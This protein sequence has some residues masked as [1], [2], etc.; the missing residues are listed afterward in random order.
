[1]FLPV[2]TTTGLP[3]LNVIDNPLVEKL[4]TGN[5]IISEK[6]EKF[7]KGLGFFTPVDL[8]VISS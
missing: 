4:E 2:S 6:K 3:A 5:H 7:E 1:M 8:Q